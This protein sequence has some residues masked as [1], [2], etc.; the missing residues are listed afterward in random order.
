M[1]FSLSLKTSHAT[2]LQDL[3][4]H[5]PDIPLVPTFHL[6]LLLGVKVQYHIKFFRDK[7]ADTTTTT[8]TPPTTTSLSLKLLPTG[9]GIVS[10]IVGMAEGYMYFAGDDVVSMV[11]EVTEG[12]NYTIKSV[13]WKRWRC[14]HDSGRSR[15]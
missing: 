14:E 2:T 9:G 7:A 6:S 11:V 1:Q 4:K 10:V 12:Y 5:H 3:P 8:L 15:G 13:S